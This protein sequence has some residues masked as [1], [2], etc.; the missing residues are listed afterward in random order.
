MKTRNLSLLLPALILGGALL[1]AGC[2]GLPTSTP[3]PARSADVGWTTQAVFGEQIRIPV[4]AF[5]TK[6]IVFANAQ[7]QA[8]TAK[9]TITGD[10]FT[11]QALLKE[12]Q[13]LGAD[14]IINVVID[15]RVEKV[16]VGRDTL[17]QETWF[18]SALAIKY[19][20]ILKGSST[21]TEEGTVTVRE[22]I[23][24]NSGR[25]Y[26]SSGTTSVSR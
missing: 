17:S 20:T 3:E 8:D 23:Y 1:F 25:A 26:S 21:I 4:M 7:F 13:R 9:G 10:T 19:T 15:K 16:T 18:G 22:E 6:G 12:A 5:E 24:L 11:Y 14:A 2:L